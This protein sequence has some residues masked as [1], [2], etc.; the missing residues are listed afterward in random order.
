MDPSCHA[1]V[2]LFSW[3]AKHTS[4]CGFST[5]PLGEGTLRRTLVTG[6]S[7]RVPHMNNNGGLDVPPSWMTLVVF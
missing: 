2:N 7:E 6:H 5:A 4:V 3:W 1:L